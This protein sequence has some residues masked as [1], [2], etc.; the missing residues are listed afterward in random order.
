[1]THRWYYGR[2]GEKTGPVTSKQLKELAASGALRPTDLVWAEG[3][4][5]GREAGLVKGLFA[6]DPDVAPPQAWGKDEGGGAIDPSLDVDRLRGRLTRHANA[7]PHHGFTDLG[8]AVEIRATRRIHVHRIAWTTLFEKRQAVERQAPHD[9]AKSYQ[10]PKFHIQN[11]DVWTLTLPSPGD[12]AD[13]S[14]ESTV[15][16]SESVHGCDQCRSVGHVTCDGCQGQRA[17]TCGHCSG[18]GVVR[19]VTC[20]GTGQTDQTRSEQRA[21]KCLAQNCLGGRNEVLG[22]VCRNCNG[23]GI[24][25]FIH[26]ERY[27]V[28]CMT[29][30]GQGQHACRACGGSRFVPCPR[31]AGHGQLTCSTCQGHKRVVQY[32]AVVRS[33]VAKGEVAILPAHDCPEEAVRGLDPTGDFREVLSRSS[34]GPPL[35]ISEAPRPEPLDAPIRRLQGKVLAQGGDGVRRVG[36]RLH[37]TEA[38]VVRLD[39]G[40]DGK[41]YVAWFSGSTGLVHA[42]DS[43]VTEVAARS[44]EDALAAWKEGREKDAIRSLRPAIAMAKKSPECRA[45]LDARTPRIPEELMR[46]ASAFSLSYWFS[47]LVEEFRRGS[48]IG[49]SLK[50]TTP[51]DDDLQ[52]PRRRIW[53]RAWVVLPCVLICFPI[54]LPLIWANRSWSRRAKTYWTAGGAACFALVLLS[55]KEEQRAGDGSTT[56]AQRPATTTPSTPGEGAD[57]R[58][59]ANGPADDRPSEEEIIRLLA[60]TAAATV[61]QSDDWKSTNPEGFNRLMRQA[62]RALG[63]G[64]SPETRGLL[65]IEPTVTEVKHNLLRVQY[66]RRMARVSALF[67]PDSRSLIGVMVKDKTHTPIGVMDDE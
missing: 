53:E 65:E 47:Y 64:N 1:M 46:R 32:L 63:A 15:E 4:D 25:Y 8:S 20:Y 16:G 19:C 26:Q 34:M 58:T 38:Q 9:G 6:P 60:T 45:V 31:C 5:Q 61:A 62:A 3:I 44:I 28:P 2:V 42:P 59:T 50:P 24:E 14:S 21:R 12:F 29:C 54:G 48:T 22:T 33:H 39:Y 7:V 18:G 51:A 23:T 35:E 56:A 36:D 13:G 40:L 66:G 41:E 55:P 27:S 37:I 30:S 11:L 17:V 52:A 10:P 67:K 49:S 57:R 43:P